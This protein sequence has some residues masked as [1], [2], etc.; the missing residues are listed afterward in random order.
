MTAPSPSPCR[1]CRS[2]EEKALETEQSISR[3]LSDLAA[4]PGTRKVPEAEYSRRLSACSACPHLAPDGTCLR[5]GCY[6]RIRAFLQ[7]GRCPDWPR[8]R[9]R[10]AP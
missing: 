9:W 6:V 4:S 3:A 10:T 2:P 7:E 1:T 8:D 5:C